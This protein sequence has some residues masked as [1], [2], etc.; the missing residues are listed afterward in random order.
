MALDAN[1]D[2]SNPTR[3]SLLGRLGRW[4]D[5]EGWREFF[6]LY[7][8]LVY[9]VAI[10]AGLKDNEAQDVVQDT[11]ILIAKKMKNQQF[12]YDPERGLFR[13]WLI[14]TAQWRI[15]DQLRKRQG[16]APARENTRTEGRTATIERIPDRSA[17]NLEHL[18]EEDYQKSLFQMAVERVKRQVSAKQFQIFDLY[19]LKQWP[20]K[21]ITSTLGCS[22]TVVFLAKHRVMHLIKKEVEKLKSE[23]I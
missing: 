5:N 10:K 16:Q 14:H 12:Q 7:W 2:D 9:S 20:V 3:R 17:M 13:S 21:N 22:S 15:A 19:V 4:E 1:P 8:R 6:N 18:S 11:F 23:R